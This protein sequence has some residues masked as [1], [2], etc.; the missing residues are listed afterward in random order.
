MDYA[1][2]LMPAA[3]ADAEAY[4]K[5]LENEREVPEY[6]DK[7]WNGLIDACVSLEKMPR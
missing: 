5:F 2:E 7:W 1:V 3:L 4:L 6:A